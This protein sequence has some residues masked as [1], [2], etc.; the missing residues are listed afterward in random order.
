MRDLIADLIACPRAVFE[1]RRRHTVI[2]VTRPT[3]VDP[4]TR[5]WSSPGRDEAR[6]I[7][8]RR[9]AVHATDSYPPRRGLIVAPNG[10]RFERPVAVR[11]ARP[12]PA[13]TWIR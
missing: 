3:P 10:V 12:G 11:A 1:R 6:E 9:G 2:V 4:W 5:P 7:L 8:R 13:W